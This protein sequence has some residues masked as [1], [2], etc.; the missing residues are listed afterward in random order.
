MIFDGLFSLGATFI[1][2][3]L[4]LCDFVS[5]PVDMVGVAV[6]I[7]GYGSYVLGSDLLLI[8]F[9]TLGALIAT[10][11]SVAVVT[12]VLSFIPTMSPK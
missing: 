9:A 2:W 5:L 12:F 3:L 6:T 4:S 10:R 7:A 8:C 1:S 11:M